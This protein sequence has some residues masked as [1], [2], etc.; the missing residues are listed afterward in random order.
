MHSLLLLI[1]NQ[2]CLKELIICLKIFGLIYSP[3]NWA[4][5]IELVIHYFFIFIN[6]PVI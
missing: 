5:I 3:A 6:L 1:D 2:Q 4:K